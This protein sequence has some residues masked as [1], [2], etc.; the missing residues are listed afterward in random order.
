MTSIINLLLVLY[1]NLPKVD[2]IGITSSQGFRLQDII[3]VL[4]V[5][6]MPAVNKKLEI[7]HAAWVFVLLLTLN[8]VAGIFQPGIELMKLIFF[9]RYIEYL[10]L[11]VAVINLR[12]FIHIRFIVFSFIFIQ[13][14]F[15]FGQFGTGR[16]YGLTSGPWELVTVL[17]LFATYIYGWADNNLEKAFALIIFIFF[18]LITDSRISFVFFAVF[19]LYKIIK[20]DLKA[21]IILMVPLVGAFVFL[22]SNDRFTSLFAYENLSILSSL[23]DSLVEG[24]NFSFYEFEGDMSLAIRLKIWFNLISLF[25]TGIFPLN[26]IFGIGF[27]ANGVVIDG[28]YVRLLFEGGIVFT[29]LFFRILK[30]VR[31]VTTLKIPILFLL[32][33]CLTLDAFSS[34]IIFGAISIIFAHA[35]KTEELKLVRFK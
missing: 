31:R 30:R 22:A 24:D 21:G 14:L 29:L 4:L 3:I 8:L 33:T 32:V 16:A 23:G 10:F 6:I 15:S 5:A 28:F 34:S 20:F 27:G 26:L 12:R 7:P 9:L 11:L 19:F 2:L 25:I 1:L 13:L 35:K 18:A 17:G